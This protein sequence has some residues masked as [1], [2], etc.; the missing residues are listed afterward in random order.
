MKTKTETKNK[1][2][3]KKIAACVRQWEE[4][5]F[6]ITSISNYDLSVAIFSDAT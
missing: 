5:I 3:K 1:Y 4:E 2:K 6:M